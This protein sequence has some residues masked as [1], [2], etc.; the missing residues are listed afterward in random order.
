MS[1]EFGELFRPFAM[2]DAED[3]GNHLELDG[4]QF[5]F[6]RLFRRVEPI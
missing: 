3:P 4:F 1:E 2:E 5:A 6:F